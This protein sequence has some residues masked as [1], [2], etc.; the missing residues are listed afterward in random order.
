MSFATI[1][2]RNHGRRRARARLTSPAPESATVCGA[3]VTDKDWDRTTVLDIARRSGKS[4]SRFV[5][6]NVCPACLDSVL[7][8]R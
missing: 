8:G 2:V 6:W 1:H 4:D 5:D 7:E 3:P